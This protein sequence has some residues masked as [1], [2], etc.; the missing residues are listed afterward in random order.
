MKDH[1]GLISYKTAQDGTKV[2][3]ELNITWY[4][5]LNKKSGGDPLATQIRRFIASRAIALV[6]QGV[7]GIYLHSLFGTHNDHEAVEAIRE[8]RVIN[9]SIMDFNSIMKSMDHPRSKK[10]RIN[11]CLGRMIQA[12]T[13]QRAFHPNSPQKV[14]FLS[15]EIFAVIRTSPEADQ[16]VLT[17]TNVT[18]SGCRVEIPLSDV[19]VHQDRWKDLLSERVYSTNKD[20]LSFTVEPYDVLWLMPQ[21]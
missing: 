18:G 19:G 2:P 11:Q 6:L 8:N 7:P 4:S 15:P 14:L 5:A 3:Y 20:L 13:A 16:V 17:L 10:Y 1:G 12:R 21:E 9:R